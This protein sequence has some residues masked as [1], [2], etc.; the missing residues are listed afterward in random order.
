MS[1]PARPPTDPWSHPRYVLHEQIGRGGMGAVY[2]ARDRLSGGWVALKRVR[3]PATTQVGVSRGTALPEQ[4][5]A[6]AQVVSMAEPAHEPGTATSAYTA[7]ATMVAALEAAAWN[8]D[9]IGPSSV[10]PLGLALGREFRTLASL[11]H[12]NIISVFDYGF[13]GG[14]QPFFTMELLTEAQ[15]L[16][17]VS[18]GRDLRGRVS[19]LLQVLQALAYLHRR[20]VLHRDLKPA[21]VLVQGERV[22]VLDF[23]LS[24]LRSVVQRRSAVLSGTLHY[25]AP[26]LL[27]GEPAS[28]ASDLYAFGVMAAQV[29]TGQRPFEADHSELLVSRLLSSE[30]QLSDDSL[31]E[32]L[33]LLLEH[34]LARE[35]GDRPPDALTTAT[36]LAQ[37]VGL[38]FA[39]ETAQVRESYLQAAEFVGRESELQTLR[40]ALNQTLRGHGGVWLI[41]GESGVGK[42]RLLDELRTHSLV[43]GA[44]VDRGQ[45]VSE[46]GSPYQIF[47]DALRSIALSV[48]LSGLEQSTLKG[49]LPELP[50]LLEHPIAD[51]PAVDAGAARARLFGVVCDLLRRRTHPVVLI[52]EDLH[53]ASADSME[54]LS[55]LIPDAERYPLLILASYREDERPHLPEELPGTKLMQL[56]RLSHRSI[57]S[58]IE[59]MLGQRSVRPDLVVWLRDQTEG[60]PF[61]LVEILRT[62]ADEAGSLGRVS[63]A[64]LH[65]ASLR[66]GLAMVVQR[67]LARLPAWTL[68]A[69]RFSAI[70]G[71]RID[72]LLL[73]TLFARL[74]GEGK[75]DGDRAAA[76][77]VERWLAACADAAV[78]DLQNESWQ[79]AHDKLREG[80]LATLSADE[81]RDLHRQV[82]ATLLACRTL[83]ADVAAALAFHL[84]QGGD[85][86]GAFHYAIV[87]AQAALA[88]GAL[89]EAEDL[90]RGALRD[91][92]AGDPPLIER[93]RARRLLGSVQLTLGE[94]ADCMRTTEEGLGLF[95]LPL[96][97]RKLDVARGLLD[98][99]WTQGRFRL[100]EAMPSLT[101]PDLPPALRGREALDE[102]YGLFA[103]HGEGALYLCAEERMLYCALC[104]VNLADQTG[105]P[106]QRVFSYSAMSYTA[107]VVPLPSVSALYLRRADPLRR[108]L[109]G[110]HAEYEFLRLRCATYINETRFHEAIQD[111][112]HASRVA[113]RLGSE[114][115]ILFT[116]QQRLWIAYVR[117]DLA[118]ERDRIETLQ[119]LAERARHDQFIAWGKAHAGTLALQSGQ[120]GLA[121]SLLTEAI[122]GGRKIHDLFCEMHALCVRAL[123]LISQDQWESARADADAALGLYEATPLVAYGLVPALNHLVDACFALVERAPTVIRPAQHQRLARALHFQARLARRLRVARPGALRAEARI[124]RERGQAARAQ[125]LIRQADA[126]ILRWRAATP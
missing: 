49:I 39:A 118:S 52:L 78:L 18:R 12:P 103:T 57:V 86:A 105:D 79:F 6:D 59:S 37:A 10:D 60:N 56:P 96:P 121:A 82:A 42:S 43:R 4:T 111:S 112:D 31:P 76:P 34:L 74:E 98:V 40:S 84:G 62:L 50:T 19:L 13:E 80:I 30:L 126:L 35:P 104:C 75:S 47:L 117:D 106:A 71:R 83:N 51:P 22:V 94:I 88:R 123:C 29:L 100:R 8:H 109:A 113:A 21:N 63:T 1:S 125:E 95:G 64:H 55:R 99:L 26:E 92:A 73:Q 41:G 36:R 77:Q 97:S 65:P 14:Q 102:A 90:L 67:R 20:G 101:L 25:M 89:R 66:G 44:K 33:R 7:E 119:I 15:P 114:K 58:L 32:P 122:L 23:G 107:S 28:E 124:C 46:A 48:P 120:V 69:L 16:L 91:E 68:P 24:M 53:W 116:T 72:T 45:A 110:T 54:I 115:G 93:V 9:T 38:A 81:T 3:L 87:A 2:R 108:E 11:R 70:R 61:F 27:L 85:A 17:Q 5:H